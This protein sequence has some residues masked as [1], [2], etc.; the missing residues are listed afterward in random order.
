MHVCTALHV[1][2]D[3]C[4]LYE[5]LHA[6][7]TPEDFLELFECVQHANGTRV[8]RDVTCND[9]PNRVCVVTMYRV[10]VFH[11]GIDHNICTHPDVVLRAVNVH[12]VDASSV[13]CGG[14]SISCPSAGMADSMLHCMHALQ[15]A[16]IT[17]ALAEQ[18]LYPAIQRVILPF[19]D[20]M[21]S[22]PAG[23]REELIQVS[24]PFSLPLC[25]HTHTVVESLD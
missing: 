25:H 1:R 3:F 9:V 4:K 17:P 8:F 14:V 6:C 2:N 12:I 11:V 20:R 22:T 19:G 23:A 18:L 5:R 10:W 16:P 15:V 7:F 24:T 13:V 21:P